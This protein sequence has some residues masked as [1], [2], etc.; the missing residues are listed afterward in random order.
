MEQELLIK[1]FA[2]VLFYV[3]LIGA[4]L[5]YYYKKQYSF[6]LASIILLGFTL[7]LFCSLD[8]FLHHW[9]EQYHALVAKHMLANPFVPKLYL[10]PVLDFDFKNWGGNEIWLHKPPLTMWLMALSMKCFGI[11]EFAIRIPSLVLSTLC[12]Y[13]TY[14]IS[15]HLF[16]SEL[17][18]LSAAG[19]HAINGFIIETTAGRVTTDHVDT[20]FM[21]LVEIG[22][23]W[24]ILH[25]KDNRK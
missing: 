21:C 6:V 19:L 24:I 23:Y 5:F 2:L 1:G 8:P 12:I 10:N 7:R 4:I 20:I 22:V 3:I 17:I 25:S 16:K 14:K 11:S 18:S 13:L 9:D 15:F